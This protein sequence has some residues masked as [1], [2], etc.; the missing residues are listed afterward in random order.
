MHSGRTRSKATSVLG[1]LTLGGLIVGLTIYTI[2]YFTSPV[3]PETTGEIAPPQNN[4][5][6]VG[7]KW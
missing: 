1:F 4:T 6:A 7:R 2:L 3:Q 5:P